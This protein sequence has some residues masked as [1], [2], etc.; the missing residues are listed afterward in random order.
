[1]GYFSWDE[2]NLPKIVINLTRTYMRSY[3]VKENNISSK[4]SFYFE[5]LK[6]AFGGQE[7]Y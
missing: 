4:K 1:M 6:F 7:L 5:Y 2:D 3:I